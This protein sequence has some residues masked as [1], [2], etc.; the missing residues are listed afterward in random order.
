VGITGSDWSSYRHV[1]PYIPDADVRGSGKRRKLQWDGDT[2]CVV[3]AE[4]GSTPVPV[5]AT[6][7]P[8]DRDAVPGPEAAEGL[9][10]GTGSAGAVPSPGSTGS[11]GAA[12]ARRT[13]P[14]V[15]EID[16]W[17][18]DTGCGNDLIDAS[19][20]EGG[21]DMFGTPNHPSLSIPRMVILR[22]RARSR[23]E[24]Q[25]WERTCPRLCCRVPR[26]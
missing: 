26:M 17:L 15:S 13:A 3:D 11:A 1:G 12:P 24:C 2:A 10:D 7:A 16:S 25:N 21:K 8:S 18:I 22:S 6:A 20:A 5:P 14:V 9:K 4:D 19:R 23:Y